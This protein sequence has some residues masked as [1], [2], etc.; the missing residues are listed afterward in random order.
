V[1]PRR[2]TLVRLSRAR[3]QQE[4]RLELPDLRELVPRE[5]L[6]EPTDPPPTQMPAAQPPEGPLVKLPDMQEP[7]PELVPRAHPQE[8]TDLPSTQVQAAQPTQDL[9]EEPTDPP[10]TQVLAAR[11]PEE[12]LLK[13][14]DMQEPVP[15]PRAHP[16]EKTDLLSIQVQAARPAPSVPQAATRARTTGAGR[17]RVRLRPRRRMMKAPTHQA[18][19]PLPLRHPTMQ[20]P[21]TRHPKRQLRPQRWN[22]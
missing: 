2:S 3:L 4:P 8:P 7:V 22:T 9:A 10:P 14:P 11:P 19:P 17:A 16:R 20:H 5:H 18:A 13:L 6:Q 21:R 1:R 15:E 12:P